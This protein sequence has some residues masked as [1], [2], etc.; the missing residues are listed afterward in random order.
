MTQPL[1]RRFRLPATLAIATLALIAGPTRGDGLVGGRAGA[2]V[3]G[4]PSGPDRDA[5]A[6]LRRAHSE[7]PAPMRPVGP[8][9]ARPFEVASSYVVT[10]P[11][12]SA[13]TGTLRW[14]ITSANASAGADQITFDIPGAGLHTISLSSALPEITSQVVI[15][16]TTQPGYAGTPIIEINGLGAGLNRSGLVL[17]GGNSTVRGLVINNFKANASN[18]YGIVLDVA[19]N[20]TIQGNYI[21]TDPTGTLS[22]ANGNAGIGILGASGNNLIGGTTPDV[23]NVIS[24]N[25]A[26][27]VGVAAGNAGFN[28][29]QGNYI[30]VNATGTAQIGNGI[31]GVY[32]NSPDNT[33]GGTVP[34]ARNVIAGNGWP[35]V[36]LDASSHRSIVKGNYLGTLADGASLGYSVWNGVYLVNATNCVI[37]DS[38]PA[39]RNVIA[40]YT[41]PEVYVSGTAATGNRVVGNY[42]G[43]DAT[44]SV[45]LSTGTGMRIVG[46]PNNFV[47]GNVIAGH[48]FR[49]LSIETATA[50]GNVVRGNRIG[51]NAAGTVP[52]PNAIGLQI[53]GAPRNRIGGT[54]PGDAN[55]VS[56]NNVCGILVRDAAATG[57]R[58]VGNLVGT[59][60]AGLFPLPNVG[61]GIVLAASQDTVGGAG[62]GEGNVV[63]FNLGA[64]VFD[65]LGTANVIRGNSIH[66][67]ASRGIELFPRGLAVNDSL[68]AD[69]GANGLQNFPLLDS[70]VVQ[71]GSSSIHGR[72]HS[73][74]NSAYVLDFYRSDVPDTS[75]FGEGRTWLGASPATT[76]ANGDATFAHLVASVVPD[77]GYVTATATDAA[78]NTSEFSQCLCLA[79]T[80]HDGLPD[81][82]EQAGWGL[83]VNSDGVRDLDLHALGARPDHKDLFVEIDAMSGYAP[84][85]AALER[86][87]LA[88]AAAPAHL[89]QNPD[90]QAGIALHVALDDTTIGVRGLP[91]VWSDHATVKDAWFGTSAERSSANTINLLRSKRMVYR[92]GLWA[93]TFGTLADDTT[94]SGIA[95]LGEG[96]GGDDFMVT[97]GSTGTG[98]WNGTRD[99]RDHA[100]TFMHELGHTLGLRHGGDQ[101]VNYKPNYYSVMNYT[102]ST[103]M[104]WQVPPPGSG[105]GGGWRLDY[106][107]ARLPDLDESDLDE[108]NGLGVPAGLWPIVAVPFTDGTPGIVDYARLEAGTPVDWDLDGLATSHSVAMDVNLLPSSSPPSPGEQLTGFNDWSNLV[109]DFRRSGSF[110]L[111]GVAPNVL[112][113]GATQRDMTRAEHVMIATL[114]PPTP[115]G[116]FVMDGQVDAS[117]TL[118]A[119]NAGLTLHARYV[120]GQLYVATQSASAPLGDVFVLVATSPAALAAAPGGKAG[121]AGAWRAVL[122]NPL[123]SAASA[124]SN[125]GSADLSMVAVDSATSIV[126]GVVDV[127]LLTGTSPG[128]LYVAVGRYATG[129][130]GAL[131]AQV[132]AGDGDGNLDGDEYQ[133]LVLTT[134]VP[135]PAGRGGAR[136]AMGPARP[137]PVAG[138]TRVLLTLPRAAEVVATIE[139][140]AGRRVAVLARGHR[141]AGEHELEWRP[142]AAASRA[143]P[144]VYFLVVRTGSDVVSRRIVLLR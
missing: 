122:A 45:P 89:V 96:S 142:A 66:E 69:N 18:G 34:G 16:G 100:G 123:G 86:V 62:A 57:N 39:G 4:S 105:V 9:G 8:T 128:Q 49:G 75:R 106:S 101:D 58:I 108:S 81:C 113:P 40:G 132:P 103:P 33:V 139:D 82:W 84:P 76:D 118:V 109:Y 124:W 21:G 104:P 70:L 32:L 29:I 121:Q 63:A 5:A 83:D 17:K 136:V 50:S 54:N 91:N 27:G 138:A 95:E 28:V 79:D 36:Y 3:E 90:G 112:L 31:N 131:L 23:R 107:I 134:A 25:S 44:G 117:A 133:P 47:I 119:S 129:A 52:I 37:G 1:A 6:V 42:L 93:R 74:A 14:A 15:D 102:W 61:D 64:G 99:E 13:G 72:F 26:S 120:A 71:G 60:A 2:G 127:E 53:M 65:S 67:N 55:V 98:G 110:T 126:E 88:F 48:P 51:T 41:V 114:P 56:G 80:D 143:A 22:Q 125:D 135:A 141:E 78:G 19:G 30:G 140:V 38:L 130:G 92:Y 43:L 144:G 115:S 20:N 94:A 137:N 24:G 12:D 10:S 77:S 87:R 59:D 111:T 73:K 68:D 97:F 35:D 85:P 116:H 7:A 46:S 11:G